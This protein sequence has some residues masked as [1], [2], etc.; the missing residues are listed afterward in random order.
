M[1]SQQSYLDDIADVAQIPND[2]ICQFDPDVIIGQVYI[3]T[4]IVPPISTCNN[5]NTFTYAMRQS[6]AQ[7]INLQ[8]IPMRPTNFT[9]CRV[10]STDYYHFMHAN[11]RDRSNFLILPLTGDGNC[12]SRT[13]SHFI[14]GN[15]CEDHNIR[16]SLIETIE[17]SPYVG[18]LCCLQVYNAL[19]IQQHFNNIRR[20]YSWGTVNELVM[21]SILARINVSYI[22]AADTDPSKWVI[23][24]VYN[25]NTLSI[26]MIL[27]MKESH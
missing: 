14:F 25:A 4:P 17:E 3:P 21:L 5:A 1:T 22:N 20:N 13:L 12:F 24:D 9:G 15:K 16:V 18:A 6:L 11:V 19:T 10:S 8:R 2:N 7:C 23:A 26:P 27:S